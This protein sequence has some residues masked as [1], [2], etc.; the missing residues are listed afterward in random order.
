MKNTKIGERLRQAREFLGLTQEELGS[1][2][3]LSRYTVM[4]YESGDIPHDKS[5]ASS[6]ERE[7]R[8]NSAWLLA[9]KGEMMTSSGMESL[10]KFTDKTKTEI[11]ATASR[12]L[13]SGTTYADALSVNIL[14]LD[15][16]IK[17]EIRIGLIEEEQRRLADELSALREELNTMKSKKQKGK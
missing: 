15:K 6:L 7:C 8:I 12:I 10:A 2:L 9:G 5:L 3:G 16:A 11:L 4:K 14:H 13:D 1:K 17:D